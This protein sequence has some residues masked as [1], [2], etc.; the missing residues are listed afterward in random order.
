MTDC[1]AFLALLVVVFCTFP[2]KRRKC[3]LHNIDIQSEQ[4]N[5][6]L[7]GI[8]CGMLCGSRLGSSLHIRNFD[9]VPFALPLVL[10]LDQGINTIEDRI[11]PTIKIFLLHPKNLLESPEI[12]R[13]PL[14]RVVRSAGN[15]DEP[16]LQL[17]TLRSDELHGLLEEG[18]VRGRYDHALAADVGGRRG[19]EREDVSAGDV[20]D[21][22]VPGAL[23]EDAFGRE[24]FVEVHVGGERAIVGG[25]CGKGGCECAVEVRGADLRRNEG[26]TST[27]G[28]SSANSQTARSESVL[29]AP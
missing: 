17:R 29:E 11:I 27:S 21:I 22:G 5:I 8:L 3:V 23:G 14:G 4:A 24:E 15:I 18:V 28:W 16:V 10:N 26:V 12:D 25:R 20:A 7:Y 19:G 2:C 9:V 1:F 6:Q 13:D